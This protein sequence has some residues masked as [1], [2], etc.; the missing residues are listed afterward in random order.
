MPAVHVMS[1]WLFLPARLFPFRRLKG[2]PSVRPSACRIIAHWSVCFTSSWL[3]GIGIGI[4]SH[5]LALCTLWIMNSL[6]SI[7]WDANADAEADVGVCGPVEGGARREVAGFVVKTGL[8]LG[9][10][11][12]MWFGSNPFSSSAQ[13]E[14]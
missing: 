3:L 10:L 5:L 8:L 13:N 1:V 7:E 6:N 9:W 12:R 11:W 14:F 2:C 4:R